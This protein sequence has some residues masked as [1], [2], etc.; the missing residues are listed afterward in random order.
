MQLTYIKYITIYNNIYLYNYT[1]IIYLKNKYTIIKDIV[2]PTKSANKPTGKAY[3]V[4]FIPTLPKYNA[5][6]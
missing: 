6:T 3:L 2:M 4:F 5:K 1:S